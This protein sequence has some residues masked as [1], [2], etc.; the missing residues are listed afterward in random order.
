[1]SQIDD[2]KNKLDVVEVIREYVPLKAVG[3]NFQAPCPFHNE[4][5][6]SFVVSPD[7]QIWHCFGC[8]KGGD[9]FSFIMERDGMSFPEAKRYLADKAGIVLEYENKETYNKRN[10]LLDILEL[11]TKYFEHC[12]KS[13]IGEKARNY[14]HKRGLSDDEIKYWRLGYS[15]DSWNSLHNFLKARPLQ[16]QKYTDEE[17]FAAGLLSKK[18]GSSSRYYDRFRDRIM[19]PINNTNGKVVAFTARISPEKEADSKM[20]KYIN[21]PQTELYDKSRLLFALDKAK[22]DIKDLDSAIVVEGQMDAISCHNHDI[23]NVVAS[24]GTSLTKDQVNILKRYS[25]RVALVFDMDDAGQLAADRG[26]KECLSSGM[27]V[28]IITLPSGKDPDESLKNNPDELNRGVEMA[29]SKN[30]DD[31]EEH[32]SKSIENAKSVLEYNFEKLSQGLD[33]DILEN[34]KKVRD[35]MFEMISYISDKTE[36]GFWLRKISEDLDFAEVD[37]REEFLRRYPGGNKVEKN[38]NNTKSGYNK[39]SFNSEEGNAINN[40]KVRKVKT[41]E[42][43]LTELFLS[44][45]LKQSSL[46]EYSNKNIEANVL[47]GSEYKKFY[48]ILIIHYNKSGSFQYEDLKVELEKEGFS[49]DILREL[50]LLAEKEYY[51]LDPNDLKKQLMDIIIELKKFNRQ[52]QTKKIYKEIEEAEKN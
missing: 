34:K 47:I 48:N 31:F 13:N 16:G 25:N 3:A 46:I 27:E 14:L 10:R 26:I 52:H 5:T 44:I 15:P 41:R 38:Y 12:L 8:G 43:K 51:D 36:Q 4:K 30:E 28:K 35:G 23:R 40:E 29:I 32:Y 21:S 39:S 9:I 33:L 2:I 50:S 37:V 7:K 6:P 17:I 20:G 49:Q 22:G 11:S 45:L 24:S 1:M 18:E 19:F 42:E